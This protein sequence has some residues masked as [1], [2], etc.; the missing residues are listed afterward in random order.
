MEQCWDMKYK[1]HYFCVFFCVHN[2]IWKISEYYTYLFIFN[3]YN[4]TVYSISENLSWKCCIIFQVSLCLWL[5]ST[6]SFNYGTVFS[7]AT[8]ISDNSFTLTDYNG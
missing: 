8:N 5:K 2:Y 1:T 7:Y 4:F 3:Y 6:D